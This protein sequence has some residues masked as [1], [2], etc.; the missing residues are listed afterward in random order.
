MSKNI[1]NNRYGE[2]TALE[3]KERKNY[4]NYWLCLCDCGNTT[5]V[6]YY[7]LLSGHTK[8]CGCL[9]LEKSKT[10]GKTETVLYRRWTA[11][12]S[13]CNYPNN[14]YYYNYGGRGIKLLWNSF[15][16]FESDMGA[17]FKP[18]LSIDR[19]D[20][21]GHYCKENCRWV[22]RQTQNYNKR[23]N[24]YLKYK[25]KTQTIT[26]WAIQYKMNPGAL[27]SRLR[28]GW[29]LK[30][31]LTR[32]PRERGFGVKINTVTPSD[33]PGTVGHRQG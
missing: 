18:E 12:K 14:K 20:N 19:I 8:S 30:D 29:S 10:H 7:K 33:F 16:E 26:E 6:D 31:A 11:I 25:N 2:L 32:K 17:S 28:R 27:T 24:H 21:D 13:R 5:I 4:R 1:T 22:D 3:V 23:N 15:E 9:Q